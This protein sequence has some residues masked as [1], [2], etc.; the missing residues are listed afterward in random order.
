M[1]H[2]RIYR[3]ALLLDVRYALHEDGIF[4]A[5]NDFNYVYVI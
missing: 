4:L 3:I 2:C 5:D 1:F